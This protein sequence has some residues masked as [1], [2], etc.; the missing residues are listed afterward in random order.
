MEVLSKAFGNISPNLKTSPIGI[1]TLKIVKSSGKT[2]NKS[3]PSIISSQFSM[4]KNQLL[5]MKLLIFKNPKIVVM[6]VLMEKMILSQLLTK[7]FV[8]EKMLTLPQSS[9]ELK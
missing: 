1:P 4:V 8:P 6:S 3:V 5:V 7:L 2:K 9:T